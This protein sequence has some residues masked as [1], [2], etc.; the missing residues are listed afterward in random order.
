MMRKQQQE[1]VSDLHVRPTIDAS[2]EIK[3]RTRFLMDYVQHAQAQALVLGI[4][5]GQDSSLAGRLCQLAAEGLRAQDY[6]CRFIALRLPYGVQRDEEDAQR[7]LKFIGPDEVATFDIKPSVDAVRDEFAR[8]LGLEISDF[9]KGNVKARMRMVAQ[10]A[11]AGQHHGLVVGTDHAAEA[12]TGFFTK[13]G[14]GGA[15]ILP[16]AGLTKHQGAELLQELGAPPE[17]WQKTPTADLL[18]ENPGQSDEENLGTSYR[19]IDAFLT[20]A[21]LSEAA[22]ERLES[23]YLLTRHKRELPISPSDT[24]WRT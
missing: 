12:V 10:Y 23:R 24:W 15:D 11:V 14:D 16:L 2:H 13:F 4:S 7:A 19:D 6:P 21:D 5:G 18:D 8:A 22:A 1:I 3:E 9:N 17:I 20:G